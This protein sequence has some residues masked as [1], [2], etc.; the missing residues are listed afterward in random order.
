MRIV[1]V[2][3]ADRGEN[4]RIINARFAMKSEIKKYEAGDVNG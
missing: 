1:V 3:H 4:I 2:S